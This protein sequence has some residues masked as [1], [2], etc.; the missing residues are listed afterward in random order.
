V[1][2]VSVERLPKPQHTT[3]LICGGSGRY[4]RTIVTP[5]STTEIDVACA[6]CTEKADEQR[7]EKGR[8]KL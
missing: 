8:R 1:K 7:Q 3:C 5:E 2:H 4:R 6:W